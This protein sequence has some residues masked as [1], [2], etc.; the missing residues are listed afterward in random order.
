MASGSPAITGGFSQ[1]ISRDYTRVAYD[2]FNKIKTLYE[3]VAKMEPGDGNYI[4]EGEM[5]G[6][7]KFPSKT[8]G[9]AID[10]QIPKEGNN[11][12]QYFTEFALGFQMTLPMM[13]DERFGHFRK[14]PA[15][16]SKA[17]GWSTI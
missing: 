4:R 9:Q 13:E 6:F 2:T 11:K 14:M 12:V 5:A 7:G 16:L 1:N 3:I 10:W 8:E 17:A 15:A